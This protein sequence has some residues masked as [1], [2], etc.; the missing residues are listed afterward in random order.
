MGY[1]ARRCAD[2]SLQHTDRYGAIFPSTLSHEVS[3]LKQRVAHGIG[4]RYCGVQCVN[5][6]SA[7]VAP[8]VGAVCGVWYGKN[9]GQL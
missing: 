6:V 3:L 9:S 7:S 2:V 4:R 1:Y 8:V 5:H